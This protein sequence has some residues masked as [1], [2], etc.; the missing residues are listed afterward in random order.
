MI[1]KRNYTRAEYLSERKKMMQQWSDN[2]ANLQ[3]TGE[4]VPIRSTKKKTA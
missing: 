2:L 4:V 3:V 1:E